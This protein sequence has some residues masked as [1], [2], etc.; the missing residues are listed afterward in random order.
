MTLQEE[1][2]E[3]QTHKYKSNMEGGEIE[4]TKSVPPK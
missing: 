2:R 3:N 1:Q 4:Y